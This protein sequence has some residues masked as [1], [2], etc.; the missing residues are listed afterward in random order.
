MRNR[1]S[2]LIAAALLAGVLSTGGCSWQE[3]ICGS[4]E[5]PVK[6]VGSTTGSACVADGQEPPKGYVRYPE[7]KVP[8]V[9]GDEWD[10]YWSTVVVDE[11]GVV[12]GP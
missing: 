8:R 2:L 5:Y 9:V 12:V 3:H 10:E 6:A 11:R 7:G 1:H 4:G